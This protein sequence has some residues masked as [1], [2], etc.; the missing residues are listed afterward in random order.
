MPTLTAL[1]TIFMLS[2]YLPA[3]LQAVPDVLSG[4]EEAGEP[5]T[6]VDLPAAEVETAAPDVVVSPPAVL[7]APLQVTPVAPEEMMPD[8]AASAPPPAAPAISPEEQAANEARL[9]E[10]AAAALANA[11]TARGRFEQFNPDGS[12]MTGTF[13]LRRPGK[14]RFDY[15]DPVPVIVVSD[16]INVTQADTELPEYNTVPLGATPLG[17][18][19]DDQLSF[20]DDDIEVINVSEDLGIVTV[21]VRDA[22]GELDGEL[23]L[24]FKGDAYDFI[25]WIATDSEL[26]TTQ[27]SL[28]GVE[29]NVSLSARLF[30]LDDPR[31]E[32]DER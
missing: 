5:A 4:I 7:D 18:L 21:T 6:P 10:K 15:D 22:T 17:I 13:A 27:V 20:D 26:Q 32:E 19:L 24:L 28:Q 23:T 8:A 11:E 12:F 25:G 2:A 29:T 9:L 3:T 1:A 16:G 31:D 14:M 30:R